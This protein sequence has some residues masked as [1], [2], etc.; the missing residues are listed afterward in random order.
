MRQTHYRHYCLPLL[1]VA[2]DLHFWRFVLAFQYISNTLKELGWDVEILQH[3]QQTPVGQKTFRNVVATFDPTAPRRLV[4]ACHYDT[5]L[6]PDNFL[7]LTDSAVPCAQMLNLAVAMKRDLQDDKDGV[8]CFGRLF[9]KRNRHYVHGHA[10]YNEDIKKKSF[11]N[12][13]IWKWSALTIKYF[14]LIDNWKFTYTYCALQ[15]PMIQSNCTKRLLHQ[16]N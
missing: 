13:A 8:S 2:H 15:V 14:P 3:T 5:L 16:L 7:G 12:L 1:L 11:D 10:C 9:R 6:K 4:L